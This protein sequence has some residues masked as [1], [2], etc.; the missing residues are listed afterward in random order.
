MFEDLQAK[1]ERNICDLN[2][3]LVTIHS[4]IL[5]VWQ[6]F[7]SLTHRSIDGKAQHEISKQA[8][9]GDNVCHKFFEHVALD[10]MEQK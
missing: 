5:Q 1:N 8:L 6:P 10:F 4:V 7:Y 9:L 2:F 3:I